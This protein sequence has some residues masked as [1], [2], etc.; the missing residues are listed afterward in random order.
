M[1]TDFFRTKAIPLVMTLFLLFSY[2]DRASALDYS[3]VEEN[4]ITG[5]KVEGYKFLLMRG[6]I[7]TGDYQKLKN[8]LKV[9]PSLTE[10]ANSRMII[11]SSPGGDVREAFKLGDFVRRTFSDVSVGNHFG[12]CM[13][14]CF[15][16]FASAVSRSWQENTV[17]LHRPYITAK[18]IERKSASESITDQELAMTAVESYLKNVR[19]PHD[20]IDI[21]MSTPSDKIVWLDE[22]TKAFGRLSPSY[23]QML[24]TK[25]GLDV[26]LEMKYFSG[27]S[28]IP[29]R[30]ILNAR[31]CGS[32]LT[33]K[34]GMNHFV[35]ELGGSPPFKK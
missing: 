12:T 33:F 32:N 27:N 25:C 26:D 4:P 3:F 34:D 24:V 30:K 29:A 10:F 16:V 5:T 28:N 19:V 14:S 17:G 35:G 7:E 11:L 13:S 31:E 18:A 6:K 15:L 9:D 20:I 21:L 2:S 23:E 22:P 8:F 1:A